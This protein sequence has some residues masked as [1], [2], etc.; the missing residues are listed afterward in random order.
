MNV[1]QGLISF[2]SACRSKAAI[3][4][5][6][7]IVDYSSWLSHVKTNYCIELLNPCHLAKNN[8]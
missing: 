1:G 6:L 7:K 8:L 2:N 5:P 3:I 4:I